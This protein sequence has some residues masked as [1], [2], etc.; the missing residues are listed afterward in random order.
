MTFVSPRKKPSGHTRARKLTERE[1]Q[2]IYYLRDFQYE[3][4][5]SPSMRDFA[6]LFGYT[7]TRALKIAGNI[8]AKGFAEWSPDTPPHKKLLF[9]KGMKF[10][11]LD[12][13]QFPSSIFLPRE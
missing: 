6:E 1:C 2:F 13:E 4:R 3:K 8:V 11:W 9:P 7:A 12:Q 5:Y 10:P